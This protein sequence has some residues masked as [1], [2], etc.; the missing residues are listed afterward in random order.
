MKPEREITIKLF[1]EPMPENIYGFC[2]KE[3]DDNFIINIDPN[4]PA[5]AQARSFL[6]E[7]LHIWNR[8]HEK[9]DVGAVETATH[10]QLAR[11]LKK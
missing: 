8:D 10:A 5:D 3:S 2:A 9:D 6:H 1:R 7:M 4:M 11:V